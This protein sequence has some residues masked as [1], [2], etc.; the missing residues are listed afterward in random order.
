MEDIVDLKPYV[1][2]SIEINV[3]PIS[4]RTNSSDEFLG[5][6]NALERLPSTNGLAGRNVSHDPAMRVTVFTEVNSERPEFIPVTVREP[7]GDQNSKLP[8]DRSFIDQL[9]PSVSG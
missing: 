4:K 6:L 9:S 8:S 1:S 7:S 5:Y 2:G 3:A